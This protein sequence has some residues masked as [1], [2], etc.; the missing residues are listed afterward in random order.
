M[1]HKTKGG[2]IIP[3]GLPEIANIPPPFKCDK[4]LELN[5]ADL[6]DWF[7]NLKNSEKPSKCEVSLVYKM[8][9][10]TMVYTINT[11]KI[12][13]PDGT[14]K[15][16]ASESDFE[17]EKEQIKQTLVGKLKYSG[18]PLIGK[19][20]TNDEWVKLLVDSQ[21]DIIKEHGIEVYGM[22]QYEFGKLRHHHCKSHAIV[23]VDL[24]GATGD[25]DNQTMYV[26]WEV[27]TTDPLPKDTFAQYH[28]HPISHT[29]N[30]SYIDIII[31]RKKG[32]KSII[33]ATKEDE[34]R[35][36]VTEWVLKPGVDMGKYLGK[37]D[38][39]SID[40]TKRTVSTKVKNLVNAMFTPKQY[41]LHMGDDGFIRFT[42]I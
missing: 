41:L 24:G 14:E 3:A 30:P 16:I 27:N 42:P 22:F 23:Q 32:V 28:N 12:I 21:F 18:I 20:V 13:L 33:I 36:K 6:R 10:S 1:V 5:Q 17:E 34:D 35:Y 4:L 29:V 31:A 8:G 9:R 15:H 37:E 7:I 40:P 19:G 26:S 2:I 39:L 38:G 11:R 25:K